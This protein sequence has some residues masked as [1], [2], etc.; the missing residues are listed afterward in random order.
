EADLMLV[1]V[2][3]APVVEGL[4]LEAIGVEYDPRKGIAADERRRTTVPH[5]YA[6]GDCAGYWQLA[7]TAFREG[8]VAA[9]NACGREA[10]VDGRRRPAADLHRPGDR[11]GRADGGRGARAVRRRDRGREV[12]VE[13][14]RACGDAG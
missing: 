4:G 6:V 11:R 3:R 5:V 14:Q 10:V 8:E 2:G 13:R 12:P 1:A 9:A 7:H